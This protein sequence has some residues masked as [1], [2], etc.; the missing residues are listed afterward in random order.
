[1][2][3][4]LR[5]TIKIINYSKIVK[6]N[7]IL[8]YLDLYLI[9]TLALISLYKTALRLRQRGRNA[10]ILKNLITRRYV[11][12]KMIAF[13]ST[14]VVALTFALLSIGCAGQNSMDTM[15]PKTD[16]MHSGTMS[17]DTMAKDSMQTDSMNKGEMKTM[18]SNTMKKD[19][20]DTMKSDTMKKD[21]MNTMK[22][23]TMN[24]DSMNK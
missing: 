7:K 21:T 5:R 3:Y 23:D 12:K 1:M 2:L 17:K 24:Q 20:M 15:S 18:K 11:M 10:F 16:T 8:K 13:L 4:V 9:F 19:T 6:N 22:S 14:A